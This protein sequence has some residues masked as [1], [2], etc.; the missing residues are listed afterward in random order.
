MILGESLAELTSFCSFEIETKKHKG[1]EFRNGNMQNGDG[2]VWWHG[3]T[4]QLAGWNLLEDKWGEKAYRLEI[5]GPHLGQIRP[6]LILRLP[7]KMLKLIQ[8]SRFSHA[9]CLLTKVCYFLL[10]FAP[11]TCKTNINCV[12]TLYTAIAWKVDFQLCYSNTHY[13]SA[14]VKSSNV[15]N[16]LPLQTICAWGR[17]NSRNAYENPGAGGL[18][19][20]VPCQY[21]YCI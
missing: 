15:C 14:S 2:A 8:S 17:A 16:L 11:L 12:L 4:A 9:M 20:P 13:R 19:L 1:K 6:C 7:V 5:E 10:Y 18:D 21:N 3:F